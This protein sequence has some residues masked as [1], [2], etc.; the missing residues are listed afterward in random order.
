MADNVVVRVD[1]LHGIELDELTETV[2]PEAVES[3]HEPE[4]SATHY[5][6]LTLITVALIA[7]GA[8]V[9]A[10]SA[11]LSRRAARNQVQQGFTIVVEPGGTVRIELAGLSGQPASGQPSTPETIA[12]ALKEAISEAAK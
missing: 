9:Q 7:S 1:G 12:Q 10:L 2:P 6:E 5:G 8:A 3:V 11:W 4:P